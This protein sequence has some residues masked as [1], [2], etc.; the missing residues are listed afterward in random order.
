MERAMAQRFNSM[1][2]AP[3]N[4]EFSSDDAARRHGNAWT[5]GISAIDSCL[6]ETGLNRAG[7]HEIEPLKPSDMPSL[8]GFAFALLSRLRSS[9]PIIWCVTASQIG[10]YGQPYA[11]G[12][13]Q[14]GISPSQIMF[15]RVAKDR[16]LSF[17]LEEAIKTQGVA[18]VIGEGT[19]PC[20]TGSRRMSLLCRTHQTPC[21]LMSRDSSGRTGSAA[22]TRWQIQPLPGVEDPRDPYGPG[23]PH[24]RVALQR[25]RGGR[26]MPGIDDA[27]ISPVN[28][29][30]PWRLVWDD[31][32]HSFRPASVFC[33][34]TA[35]EG[36]SPRQGTQKTVVG[37][38]S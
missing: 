9:K 33:Q 25:V 17:A 12:L 30:Y 37:R 3:G 36:G 14:Y 34:P 24:W 13:S 4:G 2:P 27:S 22:L 19:R 29:H 11:F 15:A 1:M 6:P 7:L 16:D 20:F 38:A 35:H 28:T 18:A 5:T 8:T 31:Q 10:D 21:L 32:T 26:A 23:L